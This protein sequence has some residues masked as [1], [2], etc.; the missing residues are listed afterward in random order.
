MPVV[1]WRA[2]RCLTFRNEKPG[3]VPF[4][5]WLDP[6]WHNCLVGCMICQWVCLENREFP[7][8]IEE[9]AEFSEG[10]TALLLEGVP[11]DQLPAALME[12]LAR[13]DLV[14]LLDVI[15]R[16]LG[17]SCDERQPIAWSGTSSLPDLRDSGA[18]RRALPDCRVPGVH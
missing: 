5:A 6:A 9:G 18:Y 17:V 1:D 16:N 10:E 15:P 14:D 2:G 13:W 11:P 4:P 3:S 12:K 8:W 7:G